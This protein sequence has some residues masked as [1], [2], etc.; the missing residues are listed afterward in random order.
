MYMARFLIVVAVMRRLAL[1]LLMPSLLL[2]CETAKADD[3]AGAGGAGPA[4]GE[5][6]CPLDR[7]SDGASC[8]S[9][10]LVCQYLEVIGN[11]D[12]LGCDEVRDAFRCED[13]SWIKYDW[14]CQCPATKPEAGTDCLGYHATLLG[15]SYACDG[16]PGHGG[17]VASPPIAGTRATCGRCPRAARVRSGRESCQ[18]RAA[19]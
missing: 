10:R 11:P 19:T 6:G 15:C 4:L 5:D 2:G 18:A 17:G 16:S 3:A 8:P 12:I 13:G 14:Q 1:L 7:P 9:D